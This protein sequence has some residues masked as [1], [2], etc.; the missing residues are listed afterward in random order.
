MNEIIFDLE[1][2]MY[3]KLGQAFIWEDKVY[4][5]TSP[6]DEDDIYAVNLHTG[7]QEAFDRHGERP[8]FVNLR[9][10]VQTP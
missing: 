4:M 1:A 10:F 2:G 3:P 6:T 5:I 9:I 8:Q 7:E